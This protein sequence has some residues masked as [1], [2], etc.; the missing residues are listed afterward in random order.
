M[1][2]PDEEEKGATEDDTE[3]PHHALKAARSLWSPGLPGA[4]A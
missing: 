3:S 2:V 4:T 1:G